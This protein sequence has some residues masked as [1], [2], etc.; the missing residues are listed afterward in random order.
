MDEIVPWAQSTKRTIYISVAKCSVTVVAVLA[1]YWRTRSSACLIG[2]ETV[3]TV[4][5]VNA[6]TPCSPLH[7][8]AFTLNLV[9]LQIAPFHMLNR[10][11]AVR[12]K[13]AVNQMIRCLHI[14]I[15]ITGRTSNSALPSANPEKRSPQSNMERIGWHVIC[16]FLQCKQVNGNGDNGAQCRHW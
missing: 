7:S 2:Q 11:T 12:T 6:N 1:S 15:L 4:T 5:K 9:Q 13:H 16:I 14:A 8:T 3:K 10:K